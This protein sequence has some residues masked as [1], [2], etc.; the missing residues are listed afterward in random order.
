M[1]SALLVED[2]PLPRAQLAEWL[3]AL[4]PA[5]EIAAE[6]AD[7]PSALASFEDH[8]PDLVFID[9]R[10]PGFD[11]LE[12]ARRIAGRAHVVFVTAY[13]EHALAAFDEG[14]VDYLLKP[15]ALGRLA[16]CVERLKAQLALPPADLSA[17]LQRLAAPHGVLPSYLRFV[18]AGD[19]RSLR[20]VMLA[21]VL[22]FQ[23]DTKYTRVVTAAGEPLIR[24]SVRE[25]L[26]QLD[27]TQFWQIHRGT[28]VNLAQVDQI[29]RDLLGRL[30]VHL[31]GRAQAL[32]VSQAFQA[33]FRSM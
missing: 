27:P 12:L 14:A 11:G 2:E 16:R 5:L 28:V 20:L 6:C 19:G 33:R 22:F 30:Q 7:G 3:A 10:L 25:L 18:Q 31:K 1:P 17:L 9:I 32:P 21:D 15:L 13:D 26:P 4:W 23:S 8:P 24:T 29:A